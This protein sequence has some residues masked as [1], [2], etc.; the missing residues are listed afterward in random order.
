MHTVV[1][2]LVQSPLCKCTSTVV[3]TVGCTQESCSAHSS[4]L[5]SLPCAVS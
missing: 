2:Y 5:S 4:R 1:E 3:C